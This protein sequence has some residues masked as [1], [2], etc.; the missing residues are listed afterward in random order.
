MKRLLAV[1]SLALLLAACAAVPNWP[2]DSL[3]YFAGAQAQITDLQTFADEGGAA[4]GQQDSEAL[5]AALA[6][7]Q[8]VAEFFAEERAPANMAPLSFAGEYAA[9][10]CAYMLDYYR[11]QVGI[12]ACCRSLRLC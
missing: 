10:T 2:A 12:P 11:M 7:V 4:F 9:D 1:L 3:N 6:D 5:A 8:A